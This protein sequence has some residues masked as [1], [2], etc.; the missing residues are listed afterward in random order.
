MTPRSRSAWASRTRYALLARAIFENPMINGS[1]YRLDAGQRFSPVTRSSGRSVVPHRAARRTPTP[2]LTRA[3]SAPC[4]LKKNPP[5]VTSAVPRL[6]DLTRAGVAAQLHDGLAQMSRAAR[7]ALR[8]RAAVRI[9]RHAAADQDAILVLDPV[10]AQE[11]RDLARTAPAGVL[12]PRRRDDR[13]A[14][15]RAADVDVVDPEVALRTQLL[16]HDVLSVPVE[17][18][19]LV[20]GALADHAGRQRVHQHGRMRQGLRA[21]GG[22]EHERVGAVDGRVH[23]EQRRGL[24]DH[25]R[26]IVVG[27]RQRRAQRGD[28]LCAA[29]LRPFTAMRARLA[30]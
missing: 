13:E 20:L 29:L 18:R 11:A 22:H 14:V 7:A 25:A 23:V 15:V 4:E 28:G 16:D 5:G 24:A 17:A 10:L 9:D 6:R 12:D 30:R 2:T 26:V 3:R 8:Q 1:T 19:E 21:L 27:E